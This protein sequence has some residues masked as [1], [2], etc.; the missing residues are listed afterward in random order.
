MMP[1]RKE[2][3]EKLYQPKRPRALRLP[4]WQA[5]KTNQ[6]IIWRSVP[7][8]FVAETLELCFLHSGGAGKQPISAA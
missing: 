2:T 5:S 1:T 3:K 8:A 7:G 4:N 6:V